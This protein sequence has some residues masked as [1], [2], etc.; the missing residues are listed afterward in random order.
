MSIDRYGPITGRVGTEGEGTIGQREHHP[1]VTDAEEVEVLGLHLHLD[2]DLFVRNGDQL[3]SEEPRVR[4][5]AEQRL[6]TRERER[7]RARLG[8]TASGE[9][10]L[11]QEKAHNP[12]GIPMPIG[13]LTISN[14]VLSIS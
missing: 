11:R 9:A 7:H 14:L 5:T 3:D 13:G 10:P 1:S 8:A 4:V 12:L 2:D 6:G